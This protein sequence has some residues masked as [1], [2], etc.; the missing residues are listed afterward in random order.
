M[1]KLVKKTGGVYK[2]AVCGSAGGTFSKKVSKQ[3]FE[4]GAF[5]AKAGHIT[6]TGAT[7]GYTYEAAK[8]AHVTNGF[9]IGVSPAGSEQEQLAHYEEIDPDIWN[10][11]IYSGVGYKAR[12]VVMLRSVDAAIFVGGGVGTL[13]E[14]TL[15]IDFKKVMG[16][17]KNSGGA[18]ELRDKVAAISH[19]SKPQ[20]IVE[21]DPKKLIS[22]VLTELAQ[23]EK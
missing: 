5:I 18:S 14:M 19:R 3:A 1:T 12:D 22:E 7:L 23:K 21:S 8:G 15:A 16:F 13:L 20:Y 6:F 17:L 9:V 2:I 11:I 4:I 10:V